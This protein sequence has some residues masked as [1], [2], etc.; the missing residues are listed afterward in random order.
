MVNNTTKNK[1]R[2]E[3][4]GKYQPIGKGRGVAWKVVPKC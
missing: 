3:E 1:E 2:G 4:S